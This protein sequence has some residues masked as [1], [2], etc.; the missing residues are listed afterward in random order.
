MPLTGV[1]F[2]KPPFTIILSTFIHSFAEIQISLSIL[3]FIGQPHF[4]LK[5]PRRAKPLDFSKIQMLNHKKNSMSTDSLTVTIKRSVLGGELF[6]LW[7]EK[8]F[9][10]PSFSER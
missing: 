9:S 8:P 5:D 3:C 4:T 6:Y 2:D 1:T 7:R 10:C